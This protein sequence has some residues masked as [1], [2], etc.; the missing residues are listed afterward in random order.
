MKKLL[1]LLFSVGLLITTPAKAETVL[2][3][4]SELVTGF[5]N[6]GGNW[7]VSGFEPM[8]LTMEFEDDFSRVRLLG[9][10]FSCFDGGEFKTYHPIICKDVKPYH[11]WTLNIDKKSLRYV[12]T[13][14]SIGGYASTLRNSSDGDGIYAGTCEKF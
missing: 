10:I 5:Y 9:E 2:Y 1:I 13:Q 12:Y 8:R 7:K 11:S 6:E 4:S 14:I 3:C